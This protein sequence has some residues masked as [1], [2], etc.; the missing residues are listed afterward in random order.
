MVFGLHLPSI[1]AQRKRVRVSPTSIAVANVS[2]MQ[3]MRRIESSESVSFF[4][5]DISLL[6]LMRLS[7][8]VP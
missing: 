5:A 2:M 4:A 3:S 8:S 6:V 1:E 7:L